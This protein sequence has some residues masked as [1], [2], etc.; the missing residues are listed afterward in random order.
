MEF[1]IMAI[2][3]FVFLYIFITKTYAGKSYASYTSSKK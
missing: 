1:D 2:Y 3:I